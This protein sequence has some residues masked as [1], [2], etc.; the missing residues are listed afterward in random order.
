M[1]FSSASTTPVTPVT[2]AS[3]GCTAEI[4]Q[5]HLV[6]YAPDE[7]VAATA[8]EAMM[9]WQIPVLICIGS[10]GGRPFALING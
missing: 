3:L 5:N 10:L 1:N 9:Q 8:A 4:I 2:P 6:V 7:T